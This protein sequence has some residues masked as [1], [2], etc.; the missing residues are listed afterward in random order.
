[1]RLLSSIIL[2]IAACC[3]SFAQQVI[4]YLP[5]KITTNSISYSLEYDGQGRI[6]E[7]KIIVPQTLQG[8]NII[9]NDI[10]TYNY[11]ADSESFT[12]Q[13]DLFIENTF[14]NDKGRVDISTD[15]YN[16][17][18]QDSIFVCD[19]KK[20]FYTDEAST[21]IEYS[22]LYLHLNSNNFIEETK[23]TGKDFNSNSIYKYNYLGQLTKIVD[24]NT[25]MEV[26]TKSTLEIIDNK[27]GKRVFEDVYFASVSKVIQLNNLFHILA[28]QNP[29][30]ILVITNKTNEEQEQNSSLEFANIERTNIEYTYNDVGYPSSIKMIDMNADQPTIFEIQYI[31]IEK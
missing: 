10:R 16:F 1:M 26:T 25:L 4:K 18:K 12:Y 6:I 8:E 24:I 20:E 9:I 13:H 23:Q 14:N 22:K 3:A 29:I 19:V 7:Q 11:S 15:F 28:D 17:Q 21:I 31:K 30:E 27:P 5:S 2:L